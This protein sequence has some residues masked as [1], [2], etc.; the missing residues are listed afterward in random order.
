MFNFNF[1]KYKYLAIGLSIACIIAGFIYTFAVHKGFAHSLDFNGGLRAVVVL[2]KALGRNDIE[3]FFKE[4]EIEAIVI[5]LDKE[6]NH[7]QIDIGLGAVPKIEEYN[8]VNKPKSTEPNAVAKSRVTIDELIFMLTH[9]FKVSDESI[10]S[11]DQVGAVVGGEL[12][13]TGITLLFSTL[14]IMTVYLSFRFQ[15]KFALAASIALIHDL[16]FSLAVIGVFQ[17]KPS[18]PIIAALLTLFGYS[19][20]DTIVIFD[21]IRENSHSKVK[22]STGEMINMSINQ[23]LGR[24]INTS[25]TTLI[26]IVALI[27]GGAVE[28][29]DFAFVLTFGIIIGTYSSIFIASPVIEIYNLVFKKDTI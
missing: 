16:L 27:I 6:K 25:F 5:Q 21:R 28:L 1:S 9:G 29:Y 8:N 15:F 19:I 20:N 23:T 17:I 4:K 10:L 18:V 14:A 2:D 24:T 26:S 22:V 11:A 13:S 12:T 3:K 7:Y